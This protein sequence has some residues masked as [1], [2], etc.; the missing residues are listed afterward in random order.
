MKGVE[1]DYI[2]ILIEDLQF[3]FN[4]FGDET[5][6]DADRQKAVSYINL[7]F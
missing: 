6:C 4:T 2:Q 5:I 1:R 3:I 7:C